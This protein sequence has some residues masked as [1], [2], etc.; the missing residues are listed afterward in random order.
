MIGATTVPTTLGILQYREL[1][2]NAS[3]IILAGVVEWQT[4]R[5]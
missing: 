1:T 2:V 4:Q 3:N 5:T